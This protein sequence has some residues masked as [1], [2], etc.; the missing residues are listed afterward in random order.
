MFSNRECFWGIDR[1]PI[2]QFNQQYCWPPTYI[3]CDCSEL[4]KHMK[5]MKE[6][7]FYNMYVWECSKCKKRYALV[8]G[9]THFEEIETEGE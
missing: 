4:A 2:D 6:N 8:K 9:T 3:K 7:H 5:Y 1:I